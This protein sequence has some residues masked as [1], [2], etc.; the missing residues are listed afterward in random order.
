MLRTRTENL[1]NGNAAQQIRAQED[2]R[3][4][5]EMVNALKAR[6]KT[7]DPISKQPLPA[8]L[9]SATPRLPGGSSA[10]CLFSGSSG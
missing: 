6:T 4:H 7:T 3:R 1:G 5:N 10:P 2:F 9:T 8:S